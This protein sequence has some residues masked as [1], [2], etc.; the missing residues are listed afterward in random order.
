MIYTFPDF[1]KEN[2]EKSREYYKDYFEI[3]GKEPYLFG[4]ILYEGVE[5]MIEAMKK[6]EEI[7][8]ECVSEEMNEIKDYKGIIGKN[9]E[10]FNANRDLLYNEIVLKKIANASYEYDLSR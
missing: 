1:N 4:A 7:N 2:S 6:C 10:G 5:I 3:A 8:P 9:V